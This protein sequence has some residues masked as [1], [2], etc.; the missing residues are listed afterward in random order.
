[1]KLITPTYQVG[2][3]VISSNEEKLHSVSTASDL[4]ELDFEVKPKIMRKVTR[5]L[6]WLYPQWG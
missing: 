4:A 5:T 3:S 2:A 1:M 6:V